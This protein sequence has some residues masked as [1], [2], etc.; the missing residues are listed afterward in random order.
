MLAFAGW[1]HQNGV[2]LLVYDLMPN[3]SLDKHLFG[4]SDDAPAL[5]WE[6]RYNVAAGVASALNYVH[7]DYD[8]MVIHRDIKPSNIMLDAAFNA[9]LGDFG[10]ARA[11]ESDKTSYTDKVGLPGTLGYIAPECFHTGRAT[12]ESDVFGFGAVVLEIVCGRRNSCYHPA[13]CS[14]LLEEAWELHGEGSI[15]KAVDPRLA[16]EFDGADAER[17]LL[18]ALACSHPNPWERPNAQAILQ[19]LTRSAPPPDVPS[20]RPAF[21]W[22]VRPFGLAN[23]VSTSDSSAT[24]STVITASLL[25]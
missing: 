7:H 4:R 25:R 23:E 1:C 3:G 10:L 6:Q 19:I 12:R 14:Q 9:R 15:L 16:G 20:S 8:Q 18:L 2:L 21:M 17:L 5:S 13:G 11:L 22:P 24:C